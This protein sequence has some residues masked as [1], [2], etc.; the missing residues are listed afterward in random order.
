ML[1]QYLAKQPGDAVVLYPSAQSLVF[2]E[3]CQN[4]DFQPPTHLILID[5]TWRKAYK[6]WQLNPWL[7]ELT[8]WRIDAPQASQYHIRA[9]QLRGAVSTLEALAQVLK[10]AY[11]TDVAPLYRA[12]EA[13]QRGHF[14]PK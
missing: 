8:A 5:A 4:T 11:H 10:T 6:M 9:T 12:F 3:A 7:A 14:R 13:M 1:R 2:E